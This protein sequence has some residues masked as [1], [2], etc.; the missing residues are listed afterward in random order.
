MTTLGFPETVAPLSLL[1]NL[2]DIF[3]GN[4]HLPQQLLEIESRQ[5]Q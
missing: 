3:L 4:L 5:Q 1:M 2:H